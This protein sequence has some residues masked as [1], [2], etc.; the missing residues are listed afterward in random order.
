MLQ[1]NATFCINWK[2]KIFDEPLKKTQQNIG[3]KKIDL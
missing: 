3:H 1:R 2:E